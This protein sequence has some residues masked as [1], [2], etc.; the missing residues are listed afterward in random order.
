M[1]YLKLYL[2]LLKVTALSFGGAYSIWALLEKEVAI[3]C[4]MNIAR[5]TVW[6]AAPPATNRQ[7]PK[8]SLL[9]NLCRHEFSALFAVSEVMPGPQIN[10]ISVFIFRNAGLPAVLLA[11]IALL[12]P[13]LI[14]APLV[15]RLYKRYGN[16]TYVAAFF[17]GAVLAT[18]SI[19][20][21]FFM[22]LAQ[23]QVKSVD[24]RSFAI[25]AL[26]FCSFGSAYFFKLNPLLV[27][28]G[29]GV[30]GYLFF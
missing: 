14:L 11:L 8:D 2:V 15:L 18:L 23:G 17:S 28:V 10:A 13:G 19:L 6:H 5:A 7:D 22:R 16:S 30:L 21:L 26:V 1:L 24:L 20:L 4:P 29:G 27:I 12:T 9:P 3:E 25:A